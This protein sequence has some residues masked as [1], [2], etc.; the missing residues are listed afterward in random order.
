MCIK[1]KKLNCSTKTFLTKLAKHLAS[2]MSIEVKLSK[3]RG[4]AKPKK[5]CFNGDGVPEDVAYQ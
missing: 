5:K 4:E 3:A 1:Y 2:N